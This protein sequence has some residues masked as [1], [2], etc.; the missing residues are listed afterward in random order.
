MF[1]GYMPTAKLL[2]QYNLSAMFGSIA[3]ALRRG[4]LA[5]FD[6]AFAENEAHF[7]RRG[8]SFLFA[9]DIQY[10]LHENLLRKM[11]VILALFCALLTMTAAAA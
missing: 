1:H 10:V 2:E 3:T 4:D 9:E 5:L 11:C 8:T 6:R 7:F